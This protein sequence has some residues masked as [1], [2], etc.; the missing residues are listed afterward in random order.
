MG[1]LSNLLGKPRDLLAEARA[2][3]ERADWDTA[4]LLALEARPNDTSGGAEYVLALAR[5]AQG[6][7]DEARVFA[8]TS[9]ERGLP[10]GMFVL[11]QL[12]A[13]SG[14]AADLAASRQWC[15]RAAEAG[16]ARACFN[17]GAFHA[18]GESGF[19][20]DVIAA[21]K[22]Y[23]RAEAAGH[24]RAAMN[25]AMLLA[26]EFEPPQREQAV[27]HL[28]MA[29]QLGFPVVEALV[30]RG[31]ELL[32]ENPEAGKWMLAAAASLDP[33]LARRLTE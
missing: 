28:L 4:E 13:Q 32:D 2:A 19:A 26:F 30:S 33:E 3:A 31:T 1:W 9:A 15:E 18:S 12:L 5:A 29:A 16:H 11:H 22:F 23:E 7:V 24:A 6:A 20:R 17:L 25:L 21:K 27:P 10:E 8:V 14:R